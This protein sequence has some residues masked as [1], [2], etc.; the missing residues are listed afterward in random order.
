LF[1]ELNKIRIGL[2]QV[3]IN[4][5]GTTCGLRKIR[6]CLPQIAKFL[7]RTLRVELIGKKLLLAKAGSINI[8]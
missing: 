8:D 1:G 2:I 3:K 4:T 5:T 6:Y 7:N